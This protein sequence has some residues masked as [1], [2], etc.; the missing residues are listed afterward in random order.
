MKNRER[1]SEYRKRRAGRDP[2]RNGKSGRAGKNAAGSAQR[3]NAGS[4]STGDKQPELPENLL[5]GRNPVIE[6]LKNGRG[7]DKI[8]IARGA[9]GS[10]VKIAAMASDAGIQ[11]Q[12]VQRAA[13]DRVAMGLPHQGVAAFVSDYKYS[14]V[15]EILSYA[16]EK[17]EDPFIVIL[18][19]IE[20]PHNLGAIIR[21]AD[22]SGVHGV[23]IQKRRA[24]SIT[25]VVEKAAAGAAEY[26]NVARVANISQTIDQLKKDGVWVYAVD[27]DGMNF[28]DSDL[29]GPAAVVVGS[30]GRGISRLVREK[31][32]AVI[33]MPMSGSVNSLNASN[34]AALAMYEV[35]RQRRLKH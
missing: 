18:D 19:G 6:A 23:I 13:V 24:V 30:E 31:C 35:V 10:A 8:M 11:V 2:G 22:A 16:A 26:V 1:D 15:E 9:E 17:N 33:S 34:A 20:D 4:R 25:P 5:I 12:Y 28:W 21:T 32:D 7:I 14:S 27:M 3:R 29:S